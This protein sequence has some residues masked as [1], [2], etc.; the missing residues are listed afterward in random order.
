MYYTLISAL[1]MYYSLLSYKVCAYS[2]DFSL[3]VALFS[4]SYYITVE[5]INAGVR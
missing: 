1:D 4:P 2:L 3:H 5:G